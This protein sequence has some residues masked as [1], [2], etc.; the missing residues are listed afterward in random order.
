MAG[1]Y[2]LWIINNN[3]YYCFYVGK[4]DTNLN[5]RL[6]EHLSPFET[7]I[8]IKNMLENTICYFQYAYVSTQI[9]RDLIESNDI[10][11]CHPICN[12]QRP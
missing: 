12:T 3:N 6:K 11:V 8:C 10:R 7:N 1:N 9:E 4:S 2:R 5:R